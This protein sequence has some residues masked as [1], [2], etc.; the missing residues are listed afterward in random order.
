MLSFRQ[1]GDMGRYVADNDPG[2]IAA[3]FSNLEDFLA[4]GNKI[5]EQQPGILSAADNT[6][7][8]N[9]AIGNGFIEFNKNLNEG[10]LRS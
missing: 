8:T 2:Q 5:P 3:G 10:R 9:S 7:L 1:P 4:A 6:A